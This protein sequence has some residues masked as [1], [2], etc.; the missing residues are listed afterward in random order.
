MKSVDHEMIETTA[1][2]LAEGKAVGWFNGRMEFGPRALGSR[3]ILGDPSSENMKDLINERVKFRE[4]FRPFAPSVLEEYA[5]EYF[6]SNGH[7]FPYMAVTN[8]I[9]IDKDDYLTN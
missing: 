9:R 3:S 2:N 5:N 1:N 8:N 7:L 4:E 6:D